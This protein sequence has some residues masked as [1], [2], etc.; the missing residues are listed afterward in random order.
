MTR[1]RGCWRWFRSVAGSRVLR[2]TRMSSRGVAMTQSA[3]AADTFSECIRRRHTFCR[4][5]TAV[6]DPS[7]TPL[8]LSSSRSN[9]PR[10][11]GNRLSDGACAA[12]LKQLGLGAAL[13]PPLAIMGRAPS[14]G[15]APGGG[16]K[17]A[18]HLVALDLSHNELGPLAAKVN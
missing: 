10:S 1:L 15:R 7:P 11:K 5:P 18:S 17:G 13:P 8:P 3:Y 14:A 4:P 9:H 2:R 6:L 16:R 12:I